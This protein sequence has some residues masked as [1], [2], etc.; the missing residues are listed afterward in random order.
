[1]NSAIK[2]LIIAFTALLVM[3][4]SAGAGPIV[5]DPSIFASAPQ[6]YV[7]TQTGISYPT[8]SNTATDLGDGTTSIQVGVS[9]F[10][11]ASHT[12]GTV[13][14]AANAAARAVDLANLSQPGVIGVRTSANVNVETNGLERF[15]GFSSSSAT[16][17][18]QD[19]GL[20]VSDAAHPHGSL[21]EVTA[22]VWM[23][24]SFWTTTTWYGPPD[25]Y[26][27]RNEESVT[28]V[29]QSV[30]QLGAAQVNP[31]FSD[32]VVE[33]RY[34]DLT[35]TVSVGHPFGI[36]NYMNAQSHV[37]AGGVAANASAAVEAYFSSYF[38]LSFSDPTVNYGTASGLTYQAPAAQPVPEPASLALLGIGLAGL[39][40]RR[41]R[42]REIR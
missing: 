24:P 11:V 9:D 20:V 42:Q 4:A 32:F 17:Q 33:P 23:H 35:T 25:A 3:G 6:S 36:S 40:V 16:A 41:W 38:Y 19:W 26:G 30:F 5:L 28:D 10:G 13:A 31:A 29:L 15:S 18:W 37:W 8:R 12:N 1:M 2:T 7:W 14:V 27:Q 21:T 22:R 34:V 39:G